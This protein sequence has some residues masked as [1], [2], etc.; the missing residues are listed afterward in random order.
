MEHVEGN[1][2]KFALSMGC[3][4]NDIVLKAPTI[5][6]KLEWIEHIRKLIHEQTNFLGAGLKKPLY[7]PKFKHQRGEEHLRVKVKAV[8]YSG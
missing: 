5:K 7:I 8:N 1:P 6:T 4:L 2:R 3:T